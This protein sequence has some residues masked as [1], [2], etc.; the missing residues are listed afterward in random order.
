MVE[1]LHTNEE[2]IIIR[3]KDGKI[4]QVFDDVMKMKTREY[5]K[6][7]RRNFWFHDIIAM[8]NLL[9]S[10][11]TPEY[12]GWDVAKGK[13]FSAMLLSPPAIKDLPQLPKI[14]EKWVVNKEVTASG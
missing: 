11:N 12:M 6:N 9:K 5:D 13:D 1:L 10:I 14:D 2:R 3:T 7:V 8:S 4:L